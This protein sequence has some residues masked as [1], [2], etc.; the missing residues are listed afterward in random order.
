MRTL[1]HLVEMTDEAR[2]SL[3]AVRR[4]VTE[5][6]RPSAK[7]PVRRAQDPTRPRRARLR[8]PDQMNHEETVTLPTHRLI[9]LAA[10]CLLA[11]CASQKGEPNTQFDFGPA[12][13]R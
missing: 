7:H 9:A 3:R 4:T 10:A 6:R 11:G 2:T 13:R 8:S 5:H 12:M 1:P